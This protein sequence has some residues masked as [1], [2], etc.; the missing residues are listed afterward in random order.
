MYTEEYLPTIDVSIRGL[1]I[2]DNRSTS[3]LSIDEVLE[4]ILKEISSLPKVDLYI[5][6]NFLFQ[7][8][9]LFS[10]YIFLDKSNLNKTVLIKEWV[11]SLKE[12]INDIKY[13]RSD[14]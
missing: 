2:C 10:D 12:K 13:M 14:D 1:S 7:R 4:Y 11:E 5:C 6:L 8:K 9:I 3:S